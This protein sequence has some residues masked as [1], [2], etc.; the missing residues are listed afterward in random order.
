LLIAEEASAA[1][2]AFADAVGGRYRFSEY[3]MEL[4]PRGFSRDTGRPEIVRL[5][6]AG[7]QDEEGLVRTLSACSGG[8]EE[9]ARRRVV[10]WLESPGQRLYLGR[11]DGD[12]VGMLRVFTIE[13]ES[14]V[15]INTF[16]V[17]PEFRGRGYGR[18]ILEQCLAGLLAEGWEHIRIEV[19]TENGNALGL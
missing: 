13:E 1:G 15:Y 4:D 9:A 10:G 17:L 18:Q 12:A 6:R 7:A 11:R 5:E 14:T 19:D 16:G 3:R 8:Q 2:R